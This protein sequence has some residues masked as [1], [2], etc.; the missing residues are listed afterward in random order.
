MSAARDDGVQRDRQNRMD[1]VQAMAVFRFQ[2]ISAAID[3]DLSARAR[4]ALVR[5][6]AAAWHTDP[7]GRRVRYSRDTLDRWMCATRA[8]CCIPGVAG[9]DSKGGS[10][11]EWLT[12]IRKV[13]GTRACQET[14]GRV[15]A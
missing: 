15:Q 6:T 13:K 10:W 7:F 2:L 9:R 4:G 1:R 8:P 11:A 12:W 3:E 14:G 5:E